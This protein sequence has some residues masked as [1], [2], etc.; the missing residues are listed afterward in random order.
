MKLKLLTAIACTAMAIMSCDEDTANIG[1]SLTNDKDKLAVTTQSFNVYTQSITADSVYSRE[2]QCF[3]GQVKDPETLSYVKSE[4]SAQFNMSENMGSTMPKQEHM[5][6]GSNGEILADS[7]MLFIHFDLSACYGDTLAPMKMKISELNRPINDANLHYSNF[8]PKAKG[9]IREGGQQ[10]MIMFSI[11]DLTLKDTTYVNR[12]A[13]A[14]MKKP[15]TDKD[16]NTYTNYGSYLLTSY[17]KH[18]EYYKNSY[19]FVNHVCPGFF[20]ELT[21]GMGV[22]AKVAQVDMYTYYHY[23]R[24]DSTFYSY[25]RCTSTEEVVQTTKVT[26]DMTTMRVLAA[27]NSCTYLKSPAGIFTEVTLPVDD[28]STSHPND[29]LLSAKLTF[30]RINNQ[31]AN[32]W[33]SLSVPSKLL[34]IEKDSIDSFFRG[35][36]LHNNLYAFRVTLENNAYTFSNISNLITHLYYKKQKGLASDPNWTSK[37]PNWDKVVL[38]PIDETS[39]TTQAGNSYSYYYYYQTTTAST[40]VA[41]KNQMGLSSTRLVKGTTENPIKL[42]VI[43]AKFRE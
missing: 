27:D 26:N 10:S 4:F 17:Y 3:F 31:Q 5:M 30:Q 36:K 7:T 11:T 1:D 38:L 12:W 15:Y 2:R 22:M 21:D 19:T 33:L 9:Y 43:Y 35:N 24:N 41:L 23:K 6:K 18:P 29:S 8:D 25:L 20:F 39:I 37:N 42:D 14:V 34:L 32:S 40:P 16:G 13:T 28:I